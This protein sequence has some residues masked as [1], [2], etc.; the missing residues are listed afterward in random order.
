MTGTTTRSDRVAQT[1][2]SVGRSAGA[3]V[4]VLPVSAILGIINTRLIISHFGEAAF[5]QYGLLVGIGALLPF[6]D[7]GMTAAIINAVGQSDD[8]SRDPTVGR[9]LTTA[10]RVLAGSCVALLA[11][12]LVITATGSWRRLLG[13]GLMPHSGPIAAALC[14]VVIALTMLVAFGQRVLVGLGKNHVSIALLGLQTPV[15][16]LAVLII[17]AV[18]AP[19]GA[20]VAVVAYAATFVISAVACYVASRM[21]HP[22]VGIAMR[23]AP[24][25]RTVRGGRVFDVAWPML[26]QMIALPIAMQT[27][28]IVL[29]HVSD[30]TN[31]AQYNLAWQIFTPVWAVT[32]AAGGALWPIFARARAKPGSASASPMSLSLAFGGAAIVVCAGLAVATPW[33]T[34]AASGDTIHLGAMLIV[35][36]SIF[37]VFQALKY[38]LGMYMTDARGLRFQALMVVILVPM[39]LGLSLPLA[40]RWGA[41]GPVV[42]STV[43]VFFCQVVPNWLYV[44]N[45]IRIRQRTRSHPDSLAAVDGETGR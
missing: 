10:L 9:L 44:R 42:G 27:D 41:V 37:M 8:P 16:L 26:V 1:W 6:A 45:D 18:D 3:R 43:S 36:F 7:L 32:N 2:V 25:V 21:I 35:T 17:I 24:R 11:V 14:L 5:A 28:R 33:L 13:E 20:Y 31:L 38:P 29:S 40:A 4:L 15:V 19:L 23:D 30:L 39:N 22:T 34:S 12:C